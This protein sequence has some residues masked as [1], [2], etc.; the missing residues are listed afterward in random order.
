MPF[1]SELVRFLAEHRHDLL[2]RFFQLFSAIGEIEGYVL[3]IALVYA[4]WDKRLAFRL[5]VLTLVAMSLNHVAKTLIANPRPF[6]EGGG[7]F[8][9]VSAERARDLAT[10]Y[11]TPSGHAMAGGAFYAYLYASSSRRALRIACIA[12]L[13]LTGLSRPYLGVHYL[14]DVLLGWP[15]GVGLALLSLRY[16]DEIERLW[17]RRSYGQQLAIAVAASAAVW[18]ATRAASGWSADAQPTAFLGYAGLLTGILAAHPIETK[19]VRFDPRSATPFVKLLRV[20]LAVGIVL[21]TLAALDAAFGA[22]CAEPS[23]LADGLRFA[24]YAAAGIAALLVAPLLF[25]KLGLAG[26][27]D[28]YT[29]TS[30]QRPDAKRQASSSAFTV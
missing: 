26:R 13:L 5:A 22:V 9:A 29:R 1:G 14:E 27:E 3:M 11:S 12:L 25:V 21:G 15:L 7:A 4:A 17:R 23:L 8:W 30:C 6:V 2:T 24:R 16:A 28:A 10:E 19:R 18:L 20:A